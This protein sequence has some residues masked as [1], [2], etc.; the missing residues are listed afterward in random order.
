[1]VKKITLFTLFLILMLVFSFPVFAEEH[2]MDMGDTTNNS[3]ENGLSSGIVIVLE[4]LNLVVF[5]YA[6]FLIFSLVKNI[7]G[8]RFSS[9]L[10]YFLMAMFMLAFMPFLHIIGHFLGVGY[11]MNFMFGL[12]GL[13]IL[14]GFFLITALYKLYQI[15]FSTEGF[16]WGRK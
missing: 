4:F 3:H 2:V 6:V 7:Y 1:M 13:Q 15:R 10:P 14:S 5:G 12:Q 9:T 8:G 16:Q 11:S